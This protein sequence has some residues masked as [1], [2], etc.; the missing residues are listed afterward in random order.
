MVHQIRNANNVIKHVPHARTLVKLE[1]HKDVFFV[2]LVFPLASKINV[3]KHVVKELFL[4][5]LQISVIY[6]TKIVILA[7]QKQL[8]VQV[9]IKLPIS[10][11]FIKISVCKIAQLEWQAQKEFVNHANLPVK[12]VQDNQRFAHLAI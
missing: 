3:C 11:I 2:Q 12:L 4:Q 7:I 6:V 1:M 10:L 5:I 8:V 9:V